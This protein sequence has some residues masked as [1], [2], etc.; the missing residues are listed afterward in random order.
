MKIITVFKNISIKWYKQKKN[1]KK[2]MTK[3]EEKKKKFLVDGRED[4]K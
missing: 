3:K 2:K 1:R 4:T